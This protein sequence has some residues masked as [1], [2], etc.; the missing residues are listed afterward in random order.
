MNTL[1]E[2]EKGIRNGAQKL[3]REIY[4]VLDVECDLTLKVNTEEEF[5][6]DTGELTAIFVQVESV[7]QSQGVIWSAEVDEW[8]S[9]CSLDD[10]FVQDFKK[11]Y[12]LYVK[13]LDFWSDEDYRRCVVFYPL[14]DLHECISKTLQATGAYSVA[15]V[16]LLYDVLKYA[17]DEESTRYLRKYAKAH[18][19]LV[20]TE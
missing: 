16:H 11:T 7:A 8:F 4:R 14:D 3:I 5:D 12:S 10:W 17:T 6:K 13:W 20:I 18:C 1:N 19:V 9:L 15:S 2:T